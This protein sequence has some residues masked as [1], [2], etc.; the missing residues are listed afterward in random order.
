M[1]RP[2]VRKVNVCCDTRGNPYALFG[3]KQH[4]DIIYWQRKV[5][6]LAL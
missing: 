6:M 5:E 1:P 4:S 2:D 3:D